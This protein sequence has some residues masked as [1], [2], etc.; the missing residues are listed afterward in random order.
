VNISLVLVRTDTYN[1]FF[2]LHCL[3]IFFITDY[4]P[5]SQLHYCAGII[6]LSQTELCTTVL[7]PNRYN[8]EN[9]YS[10]M[11]AGFLHVKIL[12]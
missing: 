7:E 5:V 10:S 1:F 12:L 9:Q 2:S 8:K 11:V 3:P 4:Y 6:K